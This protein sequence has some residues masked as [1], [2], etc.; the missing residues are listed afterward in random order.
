MLLQLYL[1]NY[2]EISHRITKEKYKVADLSIVK[3]KRCRIDRY[4]QFFHVE[5]I[6]SLITNEPWVQK[7]LPTL[8]LSI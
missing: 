1:S 7:E 8:I 5:F 3:V 2:M 4:F 6:D